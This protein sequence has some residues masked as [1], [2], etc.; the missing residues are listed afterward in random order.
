[1]HLITPLLNQGYHLYFDNFYSSIKLIKDLFQA[2]VPST[3]TAAENRKGFP[4]SMK[5]GKEWAKREERGNIRWERDGVCLALQ[6][7]DNKPV[8]I[9]S[10]IANANNY[11]MVERK[12]KTNNQWNNIR[13]KQP[14]VIHSYNQYMN[15]VDRS[16]QL[17]AKNNA[18]RKCM[19]WWKTL[20][21]H[22]IDIAIVNS[23]ILFEIHR[24]EHQDN[25]L[26]KRPKKY[27]VAEFREELV[28]QLVGLEEFGDP[29]LSKPP[30]KQPEL[31]E[32]SHLPEFGKAK[33][34]CKVCY[35]VTK[36]ELK[37]FS[38]CSAPQCQVHLHCNTDKNCFATWHTKDFQRQN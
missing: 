24:A 12:E 20:F 27:S 36:K 13:V 4:Q 1:M 35:T 17:L 29:P 37:V 33:R 25:D 31:F 3:G 10:S 18:L 30:T 19:R 38:F 26:L 23:Y 22:M 7:K 8:T 14:Q 11:L 34:N 32:S 5:K 21:F 9:L 2:G 15:G 16:D 6:W 28:R